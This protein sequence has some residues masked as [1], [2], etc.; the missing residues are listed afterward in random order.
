MP[1]QQGSEIYYSR[2]EFKRDAQFGLTDGV[3]IMDSYVVSF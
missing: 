3:K 2:L 1:S